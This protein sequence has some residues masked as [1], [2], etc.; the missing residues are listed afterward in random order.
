MPGR[1]SIGTTL[2]FVIEFGE[3]PAGQ[4]FVFGYL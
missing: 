1:P 3:P 4:P 2:L